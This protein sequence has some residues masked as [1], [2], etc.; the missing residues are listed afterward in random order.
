MGRTNLEGYPAKRVDD[1]SYLFETKIKYLHRKE[2]VK[3]KRKTAL[4]M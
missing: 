2:K 4:R 1:A 3:V